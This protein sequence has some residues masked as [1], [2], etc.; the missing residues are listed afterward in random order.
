[1]D[2]TFHEDK[3][4]CIHL[5]KSGAHVYDREEQHMIRRINF[6]NEYLEVADAVVSN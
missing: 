2:I 1:M 5:V 3:N 6:V 4:S